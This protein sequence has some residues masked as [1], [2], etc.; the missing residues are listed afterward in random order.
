MRRSLV[1][2]VT[3]QAA[4]RVVALA[5]LISG[6]AL[7]GLVVAIVR[8]LEA[9][10]VFAPGEWAFLTSRPSLEFLVLG[11]LNTLKVAAAASACCVVVG[12]GLGWARASSSRLLERLAGVAVICSGSI[13]LLL[14]LYFLDY[15][16]PW[17]G[18]APDPFVLLVTGIVAFNVGPVAETVAAGMHSVDAGQRS[19]G[20]SLGLRPL[21]VELLVVAPQGVRRM[22][23]A[24]VT[25][26]VAI[27]KDT[28]LGF[29]VPYGDLLDRAQQLNVTQGG[30]VP[31]LAALSVAALFYIAVGVGGSR[32]AQRLEAR[33]DSGPVKRTR[34][35][36]LPI[37][38]ITLRSSR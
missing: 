28:S 25:N 2:Y 9:N 24:L 4:G 7:A 12:S 16:F 34:P 38:W 5:S 18:I 3:S 10:G 35:R 27:V 37:S 8:H 30:H 6:T 13:P 22:L 36:R 23:P 31:L 21:Q 17:H 1:A 29:V 19:A 14:I 33:V 26:F 32:L 20:L 15:S 11:A